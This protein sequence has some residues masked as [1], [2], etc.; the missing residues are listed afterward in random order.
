[1]AIRIDEVKS[2]FLSD[3]KK[4]AVVGFGKYV[5][6][7][8][9]KFASEC[10][11]DLIDALVRMKGDRNHASANSGLAAN[12]TNIATADR[13][14][15]AAA[16]PDEMRFEVPKDFTV[17]IDASRVLVLLIL[18]RLLE[19]RRGYA[20]SPEAASQLAGGLIKSADAL[21]VQK[22]LVTPLD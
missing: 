18:N 6:N 1:M 16:N 21:L 12:P 17:T 13:N 14:E 7:V 20:L 19:N 4:Q 22:S 8:E 5:G 3:D 15:S 9:L 11:D 2:S 10:L